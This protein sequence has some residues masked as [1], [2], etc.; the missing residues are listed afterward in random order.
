MTD[1]DRIDRL[2]IVAR[3]GVAPFPITKLRQTGGTVIPVHDAIERGAV[4]DV[5]IARVDRGLLVDANDVGFVET[6]RLLELGVGD[7]REE[8]QLFRVTEHRPRQ[9]ARPRAERR[10][11]LL[12]AAAAKL[13]V[14]AV[15]DRLVR[16][17][18]ANVVGVIVSPWKRMYWFVHSPCRTERFSRSARLSFSCMSA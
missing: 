2:V 13:A 14:I 9:P 18:A 4:V 17:S 11:T 10:I 1:A 16:G 7:R 3:I 12:R 15:E 8:F 6:D 5:M